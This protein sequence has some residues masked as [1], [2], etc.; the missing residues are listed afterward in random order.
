MFGVVPRTFTY[1]EQG[2]TS[3]GVAMPQVPTYAA[4]TMLAFKFASDLKTT[5]KGKIVALA[6]K[7]SSDVGGD[8]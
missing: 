7:F 3:S 1:W 2:V 8:E 4:I 6:R 5:A